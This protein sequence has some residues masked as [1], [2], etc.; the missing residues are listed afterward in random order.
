MKSLLKILFII[1]LFQS[2]SKD[3]QDQYYVKYIIESTSSNLN[4]KN[5][6]LITTINDEFGK[7]KEVKH[8]TGG[9]WEL[10]IGPVKKGFNSQL[11]TKSILEDITNPLMPA[12]A[13]MNLKIEVSVNNGPFSSKKMDISDEWRKNA[14]ILHTIN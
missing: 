5:Y 14:E 1:I 2:C 10:T 8:N 11:S 12:N 13:K 6:K 7:A 3:S 4:Q 9:K